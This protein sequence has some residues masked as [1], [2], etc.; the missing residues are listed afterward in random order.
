[1]RAARFALAVAMTAW[2]GY[3]GAAAG[4]YGNYAQESLDHYFRFEYQVSPNATRPVV[5][6]YVYNMNPGVPVERIID[7]H[8][9]TFYTAFP[10]DKYVGRLEVSMRA[11][12]DFL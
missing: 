5:S 2:L 1:M 6:G 11:L 7:Q 4:D 10:V 9:G 8:A 3:G 12:R